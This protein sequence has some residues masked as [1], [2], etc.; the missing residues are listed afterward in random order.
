MLYDN[1]QLVSLYAQAYQAT[2]DPLYKKVVYETLDFVKQELTSPDGAFYSSLDADSE[3]EEGKF[4]VWTKAEVDNALGDDAE[5]F[6]AYYNI[7][8]DGN[9]EHG[10]SILL[11]NETDDA[12]AKKFNLTVDRN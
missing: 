4:Y 8:A 2:K 9:W 7:T 11:R 10:N 1:A 3:G 6:S 5:I 12:V